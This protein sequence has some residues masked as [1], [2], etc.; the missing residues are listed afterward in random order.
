MGVILAAALG[1]ILVVAVLRTVVDSKF[2]F[3]KK[4]DESTQKAYLALVIVAAAI[5]AAL[6]LPDS[7]LLKGRAVQVGYGDFKATLGELQTRVTTLSDQVEAF[8]K[9]KRREAFYRGHG[10]DRVH[11][12]KTRAAP[13]SV[14]IWI[15]TLAITL[16]QEPIPESIDIVFEGL[17]AVNLPKVEGKTITGDFEIGTKNWKDQFDLRVS[18][19]PRTALAP[20]SH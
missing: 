1:V 3:I 9:L 19:Y 2:P 7:E 14:D 16:E 18:Y 12:L 11:L 17:P 5:W 13:N 8:F 6:Y 4:F 15:R 20:T 10:M